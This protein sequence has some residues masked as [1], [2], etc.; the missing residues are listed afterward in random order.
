MPKILVPLA[1]IRCL[2]RPERQ[3]QHHLSSSFANTLR[4]TPPC[5][6][7]L[8]PFLLS[9]PLS[10]SLSPWLGHGH[11]ACY[12]RVALVGRWRRAPDP[13]FFWARILYRIVKVSGPLGESPCF[14]KVHTESGS[15]ALQGNHTGI[16]W[17]HKIS[18]VLLGTQS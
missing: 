18:L 1:H 3:A 5:S 16:S 11:Q 9:L 17:M 13:R 15:Q 12:S 7:T 2:G 8:L 14:S 4:H 10:H 6:H